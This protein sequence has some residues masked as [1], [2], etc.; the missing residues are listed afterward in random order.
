MSEGGRQLGVLDVGCFSAHLLV[1]AD[2]GLRPVLEHKVRLRL[3]QALD[4][5]SRV[6]RKGVEQVVAAVRESLEVAE[7]AGVRHIVPY[8]TSVL[9]DAPNAP[10]VFAEIA[11]ETG[12]ALHVLS[13]T[14]EARLSYLAARRWFGA[15]PLLVLDIGGGTVEVAAGDGGEPAVV[16]SL[17]YGARALTRR[18]VP[19][20]VVRRQ[21]RDLLGDV[22]EHRAVG[23]SKVFQQLAR[24]VGARP[25][26]DGV[27]VP[28]ALNVTDLR[29]WIP[30]LASMPPA[31]RAALPG[32]SRHRAEQAHAG[33]VVA[34]TLMR[35]TGHDEVVICPWSS[36]EGLLLTLLDDAGVGGACRVA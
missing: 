14:E 4:D 23:C 8:A 21:V 24:L 25:Q 19:M 2:H 10:E 20:K 29:H 3:D 28:R 31:K 30:R 35:A 18:P 5:V 6:R 26:R 33:A 13:G 16:G 32:I 1:V 17:P 22:R 9:R 7:R 15:G 11:A 12:V 34:E 36:R 27:A